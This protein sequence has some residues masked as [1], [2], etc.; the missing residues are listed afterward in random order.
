MHSGLN[1]NR[2]QKI[3]HEHIYY[4]IIK[5]YTLAMLTICTRLF[6]FKNT[7]KHT[8]A[9]IHINKIRGEKEKKQANKQAYMV[10]FG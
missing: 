2:E 6:K 7:N 8:I 10:W 9:K 4:F 1:D 3:C 5:Q